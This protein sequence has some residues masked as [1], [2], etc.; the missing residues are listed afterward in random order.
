MRTAPQDG[1]LTTRDCVSSNSMC[2]QGLLSSGP[3]PFYLYSG[4]Y[5]GTLCSINSYTQPLSILS[6]P[7]LTKLILPEI[8][9]AQSL[10]VEPFLQD[11]VKIQQQHWE[12]LIHT[13]WEAPLKHFVQNSFYPHKNHMRLGLLSYAHDTGEKIG[14]ERITCPRRTSKWQRQPGCIFI[15]YSLLPLEMSS[16]L[17]SCSSSSLCLLALILSCTHAISLSLSL[18]LSFS[19]SLLLSPR[20][21]LNVSSSSTSILCKHILRHLSLL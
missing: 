10:T 11:H 4:I 16:S 14:E 15:Q 8:T 12:E 9:S 6:V 21:R 20:F 2:F 17:C 3:A 5:P 18:W 19:L 13:E 7:S 1:K